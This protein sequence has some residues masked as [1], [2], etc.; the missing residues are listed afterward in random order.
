MIF[1][2]A[3]YNHCPQSTEKFFWLSYTL[4]WEQAVNDNKK[5]SKNPPTKSLFRIYSKC[6]LIL[7]NC[8]ILI[9]QTK[10]HLFY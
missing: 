1:S 4:Y 2:G 8:N 9:Q 5:T 7:I 3:Y 6:F 10:S